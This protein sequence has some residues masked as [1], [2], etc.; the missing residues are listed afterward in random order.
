MSTDGDENIPS[1]I[2]NQAHASVPMKWLER[3]TALVVGTAAEISGGYAVFNSDNQAGTVALLLAGAVFLLIGVQGTRLIRMGTES[4]TVELDRRFRVEKTVERI[5]EEDD[6]DVAQG[7]IEAASIIDPRV[8]EVMSDTGVAYVQRLQH[9]IL[10][11][12]DFNVQARINSPD[13]GFDIRVDT[14]DSKKALVVAKPY[15]TSRTFDII[16]YRRATDPIMFAEDAGILIA[17]NAS[18]SRDVKEANFNGDPVDG[19]PVEAITWRDER[20]NDILVRA[21]LRVAR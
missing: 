21:L 14:I 15:G 6:P 4:S 2:P 13:S 8:A 16:D 9:A 18:L 20:D 7:M 19:R 10:R 5:R 12:V 3:A 11:S 17:T 1:N